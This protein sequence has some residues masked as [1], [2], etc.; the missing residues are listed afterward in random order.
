M[1]APTKNR[2]RPTAAAVPIKGTPMRPTSSP[3]A[4]A[5]VLAIAARMT[6]AEQCWLLKAEWDVDLYTS[7]ERCSG[8]GRHS[9]LHTGIAL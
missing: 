6:G 2:M 5:A 3:S 7:R 9:E 8:R 1:M 4:P